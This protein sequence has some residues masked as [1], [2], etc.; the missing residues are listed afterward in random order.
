MEIENNQRPG[1]SR[2]S[3]R[4]GNNLHDAEIKSLGL[5]VNSNWC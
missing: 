4:Q 5:Y 2:K 3:L 1:T